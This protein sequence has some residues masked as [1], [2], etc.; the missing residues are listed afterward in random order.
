MAAAEFVPCAADRALTGTTCLYTMSPDQHFVVDRMPGC[1]RTFVA[2][3]FSGH[4]FKFMP[5]MGR[6]LADLAC[7]G[8]TSLPIG[9]LAAKRFAKAS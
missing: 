6:V 4:G 2:C 1:A 9:F 7:D 8:A 5:V 3:G